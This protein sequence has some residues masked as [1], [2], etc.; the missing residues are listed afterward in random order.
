MSMGDWKKFL[1][2]W[3]LVT[4]LVVCIPDRAAAAREVQ[5]IMPDDRCVFWEVSFLSENTSC[6]VLANACK[7]KFYVLSLVSVHA[8]SCCIM[9]RALLMVFH[10]SSGR[11][12]WSHSSF[13]RESA[14]NHGLS[15]Y[16]IQ[17]K[18]G[19]SWNGICINNCIC[20]NYND[21][22][23][24]SLEIMV[25]KGNHPQMALIQVSELL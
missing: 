23:A 15:I 18:L 21:L 6:L 4:F 1:Q 19:T 17:V 8:V 2:G 22:T 12:H 20:V 5:L 16:I 11:Q 7:H 10:I 13:A 3:S 14:G 9:I 25:N 24:T